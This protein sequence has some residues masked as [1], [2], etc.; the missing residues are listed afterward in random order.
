MKTVR[1]S[2]GTLLL[3]A[4]LGSNQSDMHASSINWDCDSYCIGVT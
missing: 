1:N 4:C 2:L 3:L